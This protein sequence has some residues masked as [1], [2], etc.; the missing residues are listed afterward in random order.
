[1][2][3]MKDCVPA[4]NRNITTVKE[5]KAFYDSKRVVGVT[6]LGIGQ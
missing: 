6:C 3:S 5:M 2:Q 1:M 4:L